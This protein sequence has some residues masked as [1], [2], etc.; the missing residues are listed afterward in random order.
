MDRYFLT[1][2]IYYINDKPHLGSVSETIAAD[3]IARYQR[4][5][6]KQVLF[7]TGTDEHSQKVERTALAMGQ[8]VEQYTATAAASWKALF[9]RLG[10]S[11]SRFIRTTDADHMKVVQ[12]MFQK[13]YDQGDIYKGSYD[14][15]Y[16]I[17]DEAFLLESDLVEGKCPHCGLEVQHV[18]EVNY[19]FRLSKYQD[20]LLAWY[21]QHPDFVQPPMRYNELVNVIKGGLHD[22][23]VSRSTVKWGVPVPFDTEQTV[24]VWF[25]ALI[26]YATVAGYGTE[27]FVTDW[28]ADL[29]LIGK[30]ITRF[31][32]IIW[33]AMLMALNLPLPRRIFA[34]GF[35]NFEGEKMSKSL[36]NVVDPAAL[37][38]NL[39][40]LI[41]IDE[42]MAVDALRYYLCREG[43]YGLDVDFSSQRLLLRFNTDLANDLGNLLNRTLNMFAK[44]RPQIEGQPLEPKSALSQLF[45]TT[46]STVSA[47]YSNLQFSAGLE[48][49]WMLV[50]VLNKM[51]ED[52]KPWALAK[53]GDAAGLATHLATLLTGLWYVANLVE[54][55][56]PTVSDRLLEAIRRP[57]VVWSDLAWR[58]PGS[59][60]PE[61]SSTVLFP[62]IQPDQLE[63]FLAA[64]TARKTGTTT[65]ATATP[66]PVAVVDSGLITIDD[67]AKVQLRIARILEGERVPE[68]DKLVKL[69]VK[70]GDEERTIVAG[71][72]KHY[73]PAALVGKQ[74][75]IVANLQPRKLKG[76]AS[77]GML[78]AASAG[79][80]MAL[81]TPM[82]VL[83]DGA[84]IH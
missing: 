65:G 3:F 12:E 25:D 43:T 18:S 37:I 7:S 57:Q 34:H 39:S 55:C 48:K 36:G 79:D 27:R 23:S 33:P 77:Q 8:P 31:H 10:I 14:G 49:T 82:T 84:E 22:V 32:G 62:R 64:Q 83:P 51:I 80:E 9:D 16:C 5:L 29:H 1:T 50:N 2:A 38:E 30:D 73:D 81:L 70:V 54:P 71:I 78:L 24:Y 15:W 44:F 11:Y 52:D 19:F 74:I 46:L 63:E 28:P 41:G 17:R 59:E 75:V 26:N 68:T 53:V 35:W 60:L 72:G 58:G 42:P 6:G 4:K 61:A 21:E 76:I 40:H 66:P 47:D 69:R 45:S 56:M 13:L 67:V 20:T